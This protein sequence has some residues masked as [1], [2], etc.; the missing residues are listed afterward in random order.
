MNKIII[1][2]D[3]GIDPIDET[4][5]IAGQVIKDGKEAYRDIFEIS[6]K[7]IFEET[8][9][10]H[11]FTTSSPLQIDYINK[12]KKLLESGNDVIH[13][14]M[15]SG[16]SEGSVNGPYVVAQELNEEYDNNVYIIDT[17]NATTG[18]T[19]ID[20]YAKSLV[21]K[22][23]SSK[24][25]VDELNNFKNYVQTSFYVP[26]PAGF[27]RSGR[28]KGSIVKEKALSLS[29]KIVNLAGIKIRVD[30][31]NEGNL[32]PRAMMRG[33]TK[34]NI[35]KMLNK[36][37][38]EDTIESYDS[39][40]VVIGNLLEKDVKIDEVKEYIK[41]FYYFKNV[42]N[43]DINDVVTSYGSEDLCGISLVK[44]L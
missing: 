15:S 6:N 14:C 22:G 38:N 5:M 37:I 33:K 7:E 34:E 8:R 30:F 42:I 32:Y 28:N 23:L 9:N 19:L 36:I 16:I 3:S 31:N 10:G 29:E 20:E 41:S 11:L 18:G 21:K 24:E 1:T 13:L 27:L 35:M 12:F 39:N 2:Q 4:N 40:Y 25:I 44:K 17:L 43:K 26:Y